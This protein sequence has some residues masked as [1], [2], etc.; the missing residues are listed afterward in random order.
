M[1]DAQEIKVD[2]QTLEEVRRWVRGEQRRTEEALDLIRQRFRALD[3]GWV[4][5]AGD[6]FTDE[7]RERVLPRLTRLIDGLGGLDRSLDQIIKVNEEA[8]E[9]S[10]RLFIFSARASFL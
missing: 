5:T 8:E 10:A 6:A 1:S 9:N 3:E 7:M 2:Y 4:G